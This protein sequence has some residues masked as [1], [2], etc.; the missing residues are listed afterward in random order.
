MWTTLS[1]QSPQGSVLA[2]LS[3]PFPNRI[4]AI[5][6]LT[7]H[8]RLAKDGEQFVLYDEPLP[9]VEQKDPVT[10]FITYAAVSP[11]FRIVKHN[12]TE[13][14]QVLALALGLGFQR[15]RSIPD[16]V[17]LARR[18]SDE[19]SR[20][21]CAAHLDLR[22]IAD[23]H[24]H[25]NLTHGKLSMEDADKVL[26][27]CEREFGASFQQASRKDYVLMFVNGSFLMVGSVFS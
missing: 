17:E 21:E 1:F 10:G 6:G 3:P 9:L 18:V 13:L 15:N 4:T 16:S 22:E 11:S 27:L 25:F 2:E 12:E 26:G 7:K 19:L 5:H 8:R 14:D 24:L 20:L 23:G